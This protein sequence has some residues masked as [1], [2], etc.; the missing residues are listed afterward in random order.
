MLLL[1]VWMLP[2]KERFNC[3]K[4]SD[5]KYFIHFLKEDLKDQ[6]EQRRYLLHMKAH[7][8]SKIVKE[9]LNRMK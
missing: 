2:R 4:D 1:K 6:A 8:I 9:Q 7:K 3:L 5:R